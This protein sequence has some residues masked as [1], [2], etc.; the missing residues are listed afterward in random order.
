L[1]PAQPFKINLFLKQQSTD[2]IWILF[3]GV[4]IFHLSNISA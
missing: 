3:V 1:Q 4:V 2:F